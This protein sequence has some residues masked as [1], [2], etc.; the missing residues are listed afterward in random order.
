MIP[1]Q[2]LSWDQQPTGRITAGR[3]G[4][5]S[6]GDV[7][8]WKRVTAVERRSPAEFVFPSEV[9]R[10]AWT[11]VPLRKKAASREGSAD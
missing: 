4:R 11:I 6:E 2:G 1:T 8:A 5:E 3:L 10:T 9:R 7:V